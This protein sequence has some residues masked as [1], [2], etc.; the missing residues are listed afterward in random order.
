MGAR[1]EHEVREM[2][3]RR[4]P[5]PEWAFL[6]EV[7][8]KTGGGASDER[9]ADALAMNMWPSRGMEVLGFEIK[10]YRGDWTRELKNPE[11]STAVQKFCDRW[12]IVAAG[13]NIVQPGELP[14]TWGLMVAHGEKQKRLVCTKEA[15]KLKPEPLDRFFIASMLRRANEALERARD[16]TRDDMYRKGMEAGRKATETDK[17]FLNQKTVKDLEALRQSIKMFEEASGVEFNQHRLWEY[18]HIGM[19]VRVVLKH[20]H[21]PQSHRVALDRAIR[22]LEACVNAMKGLQTAFTVLEEVSDGTQDMMQDH[23]DM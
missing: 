10:C 5:A 14:P 13:K 6:E 3:R 19:A 23:C 22:P 16:V 2:L 17:E 1:N 21:N 8:N 20:I 12:W 11:K 18:G 9:Y 4:Y 15:P 7:R